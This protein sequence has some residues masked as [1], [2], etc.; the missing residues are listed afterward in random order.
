MI[1]TPT[2]LLQWKKTDAEQDGLKIRGDIHTLMMGDPG[3]TELT[4][5]SC[6]GH[7]GGRVLFLECLFFSQFAVI[8]SG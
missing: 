5:G 8:C 2:C 6:G 3:A 4:M 1:A 7:G